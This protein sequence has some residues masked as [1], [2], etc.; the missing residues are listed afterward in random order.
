MFDLDNEQF[1]LSRRRFAE[2][3]LERDYYRKKTNITTWEELLFFS[4]SDNSPAKRRTLPE[5]YVVSVELVKEV[6]KPLLQLT[7]KGQRARLPSLLSCIYTIAH[8]EDVNC[9]TIAALA[10]QLVFSS[11][12]DLTTGSFCKDTVH[13]SSSQLVRNNCISVEKSTFLLSQLE[14]GKR[15]Y[16]DLKRICKSEGIIF[17]SYKDVSQYRSTITLDKE[18]IL[19]RNSSNNTIGIGISYR[20]LLEQ[21]VSQILET[22][23]AE[24]TFELPLTCFASDGL[25]GSGWHKIYNQLQESPNLNSKNYICV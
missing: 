3:K 13:K 19:I 7:T 17:P 14:I 9:K 23:P 24:K 1:C 18:L 12:G 5:R 25:D 21:T 20:S 15:K 4:Y 11:S 16:A 2:L 8:M 6:R 10:L 22:L